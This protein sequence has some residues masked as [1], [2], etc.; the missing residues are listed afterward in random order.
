[1]N[2]NLLQINSIDIINAVL[3]VDGFMYISVY[4]IKN[5]SLSTTGDNFEFTFLESSNVLLHQSNN[6]SYRIS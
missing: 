5:P 1:M 4:G 3:A 2:N 6:L